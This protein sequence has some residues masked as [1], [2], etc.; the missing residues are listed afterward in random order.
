M[1]K[2][3]I[4]RRWAREAGLTEAEAADRLDVAVSQILNRI[5]QGGAAPLPGFGTL[6]RGRD[7]KLLFEREGARHDG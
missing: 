2:P 1:N 4:A 7:G 3:E 6:R 5:R